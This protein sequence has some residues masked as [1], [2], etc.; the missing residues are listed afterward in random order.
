[1]NVLRDKNSNQNVSE[2]SSNSDTKKNQKPIQ[3][4]ALKT[5]VEN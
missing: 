4:T 5:F 1:M 2:S 3:I